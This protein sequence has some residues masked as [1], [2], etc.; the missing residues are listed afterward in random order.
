MMMS[1]KEIP[2]K[3][4]QVNKVGSTDDPKFWHAL[5]TNVIEQ[6]KETMPSGVFEIKSKDKGEAVTNMDIEISKTILN[7]LKSQIPADIDLYSEE[8]PTSRKN[9]DGKI[10]FIDPIDNTLSLISGFDDY[11]ISVGLLEDGVAK[12]GFVYLPAKKTCYYVGP[13]GEAFYDGQIIKPF[14]G[15][16]DEKVRG[17]GTCAFVRDLSIPKALNFYSK[18]LK[19]KVPLRITGGAALGLCEVASGRLSGYVSYGAHYWD[20][21]GGLAVLKAAGGF[22]KLF[23]PNF[24]RF[25]TGCIAAG[26][27]ENLAQLMKLAGQS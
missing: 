22:Y 25:S 18:M 27:R 6:I 12:S 1:S 3:K 4:R 24:D 9:L 26:T 14:S 2:Q 5:W 17:V 10:I 15:K 21:A 20:L 8:S 23:S 19:A 13:A 7:S 16:I 11:T